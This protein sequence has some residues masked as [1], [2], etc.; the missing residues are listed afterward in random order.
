MGHDDVARA[1]EANAPVWTEQVR[2]GLEST[3][4]P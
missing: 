3:V 4:T 2:R 1:W